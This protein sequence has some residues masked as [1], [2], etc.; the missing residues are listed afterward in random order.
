MLSLVGFFLFEGV[1][2]V[3]YCHLVPRRGGTWV[4]S[5][6]CYL[7]SAG[8]DGIRRRVPRGH[9]RTVTKVLRTTFPGK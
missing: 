4:V 1:S 3:N 8:S 6:W 2:V 7:D 9:R 5:V